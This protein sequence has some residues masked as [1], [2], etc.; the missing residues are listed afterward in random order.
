MTAQAP[1][2]TNITD[3]ILHIEFNRP[4]KKN[5][6]TLEMYGLAAAALKQAN[7]DPAI[8]VVIISGRGDDFTSGNDLAD[9]LSAGDKGAQAALIEF[10]RALPECN[11][12]VIAAVHG[13]AIGIG[14][15]L[16]LHCDLVIASP[17]TNLQMPF[18]KLGLCPEFGSSFL[19]PKFIGQRRATELLLLG[20]AIDGATALEYGLINEVSEEPLLSALQQAQVLSDLPAA[21]VRLC[22]SLLLKNDKARLLAAIEAEGI[23]FNQRMQSAEAIEAMTAFM[24]RRDPDFRQFD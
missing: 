6:L 18:V 1:L 2:L 14:T 17:S 12:P 15:T 20:K 3:G 5:A 19:L 4:N 7:A 21:A 13:H 11:K 9:F 23:E 8:R 22:K 16:L 10:L 24:E